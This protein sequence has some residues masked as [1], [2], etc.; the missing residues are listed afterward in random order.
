[1]ETEPL[2]KSARRV[3]QALHEA[4][5]S[6]TVIEHAQ[7]TRTAAEAAQAVGADI[8]QIVKSLVMLRQDTREPI[9]ILVSGANRVDLA[10]L[11]D[12]LGF[13]VSLADAEA[14]RELTG[15]GIGGVPPIGHRRHLPTY[16]DRDLAQ[17]SQL[18]AAAG[19]PRAVFSLA[20]AQLAEMSGGEWI[21]VAP[22]AADI[23][24][25]S[26]ATPKV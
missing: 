19:T 18:W 2:S 12:T 1:V 22:T 26:D 13:S 16:I 6:L 4:G 15:Y 9:L 11:S 3:Q 24:K 14:V 23:P 10:G 5:H 21:T 17:W 25:V 20:P 7:S 8:G